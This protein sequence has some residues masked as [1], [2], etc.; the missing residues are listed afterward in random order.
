MRDYMD[1]S[2]GSEAMEKA[3]KKLLEEKELKKAEEDRKRKERE[4]KK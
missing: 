1:N 2:K 4:N 3:Y